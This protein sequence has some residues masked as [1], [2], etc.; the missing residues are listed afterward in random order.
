[1][2]ELTRPAY[3]R[4]LFVPYTSAAGLQGILA[5]DE[6]KHVR[7][8]NERCYVSLKQTN[9]MIL[10]SRDEFIPLAGR[11]GVHVYYND[12]DDEGTPKII[13]PEYL[14]QYVPIDRRHRVV[15]EAKDVRSVRHE[16]SIEG[17]WE[18]WFPTID[19]D[20]MTPSTTYEKDVVKPGPSWF[21]GYM[22]AIVAILV[23][24]GSGVIFGWY[25][26]LAALTTLFLGG[27]F[28]WQTS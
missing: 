25:A 16:K 8:E 5:V 12:A 7:I 28:Q 14:V 20:I 22:T 21:W 9:D 19:N 1:M 4:E 26:G 3:G 11:L 6:I 18:A 23:V 13:R 27:L 15:V 17:S 10:L 24:I 2:T